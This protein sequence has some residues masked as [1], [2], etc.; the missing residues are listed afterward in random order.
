[1]KVPLFWCSRLLFNQSD[2]AD[3]LSNPFIFSIQIVYAAPSN[4]ADDTI[5]NEITKFRE[6]LQCYDNSFIK[7]AAEFRGLDKLYVEFK[8]GIEE[9]K[10]EL[11]E[12]EK[13][14]KA[15]SKEE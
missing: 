7:L 11:D 13:I 1:M 15:E 9:T 10:S 2:S 8:V 5:D 3:V 12:C 4:D 6:K 14:E